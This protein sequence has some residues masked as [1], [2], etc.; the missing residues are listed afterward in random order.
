MSNPIEGCEPKKRKK[1]KFFFEIMFQN[2]K[3]AAEERKVKIKIHKFRNI[4]QLK[5]VYVVS[6]VSGKKNYDVTV[7]NFPTCT[8]KDFRKN[9]QQVFCKHILLI[10]INVL[11][12]L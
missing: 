10:I 12:S 4:S 2:R 7:Y 9:G 11:N 3:K 8:C 5:R 6:S 1:W